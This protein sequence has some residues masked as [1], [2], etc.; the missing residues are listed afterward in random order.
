MLVLS[1]QMVYF[2]KFT[3]HIQI[4]NLNLILLKIKTSRMKQFLEIFFLI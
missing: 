4:K 2:R 1:K 3:M